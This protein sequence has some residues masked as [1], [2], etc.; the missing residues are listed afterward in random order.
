MRMKWETHSHT[1]QGSKC[2]WLD[3]AESVRMHLEAGYTGIV[4]TDH[5]NNEN[6]ERFY[7]T[8][9]EQAQAWL[10][11][12]RAARAAGDR[13]GLRVLFGLE[14]R[15]QDCDNDYLIFGAE[16]GFVLENPRLNHLT[17]PELHA[18]CA[19]YGAVLVQAHP[20]RAKC[21]PAPPEDLDGYEVLNAN[22][23]HENDNARTE[24][25]A[26][27]CPGLIRLCGSDFHRP[28]DIGRGGILTERDIHT[29]AEMAACLRGGDFT[30]IRS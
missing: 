21:H 30:L 1:R 3:A 27:A 12:W 22:I 11:G 14:A 28:E 8:P 29:S 25:L 18:L 23:R 6:L 24:A 7:G 17:L 9:L 26:D 5:Y 13:E 4:I 15:L 19:R 2:G 10:S 20:C 16:P